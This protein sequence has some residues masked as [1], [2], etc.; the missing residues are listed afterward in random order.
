MM[1]IGGCF[2]WSGKPHIM[3][4]V[5][6]MMSRYAV[7]PWR[8]W[9]NPG[10]AFIPLFTIS[11][12]FGGPEIN[13]KSIWNEDAG[14]RDSREVRLL[15]SRFRSFALSQNGHRKKGALVGIEGMPSTCLLVSTSVRGWMCPIRWCHS[16]NCFIACEKAGGVL[17]FSNSV[18]ASA[19]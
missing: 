17:R 19:T 3:R 7:L 1:A 18:A 14:S 10:F 12:R 13:P 4:V 6:Q 16:S 9:H 2:D 15:R 11:A 5:A 8:S